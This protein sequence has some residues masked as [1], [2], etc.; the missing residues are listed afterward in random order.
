MLLISGLVSLA[1]AQ[2]PLESKSCEVQLQEVSV[3]LELTEREM[4]QAKQAASQDLVR[5]INRATAAE[6]RIAALPPATPGT[7]A[8]PAGEG[9]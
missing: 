3:Q 7:P 6:K 9:R 2:Q 8:A 4:K 5:W 1:A